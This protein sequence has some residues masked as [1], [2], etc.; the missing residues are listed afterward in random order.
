ASRIVESGIPYVAFGGGEP[1]GVPH[2]WEI[3]E[4][5]AAGGVALKLETDGT[6]ID[7]RAAERLAALGVECVQI[8]V[9]GATA[10][11]HQRVRPGGSFGPASGAIPRAVAR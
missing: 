7:E 1:L 11:P 6:R 4:R 3:F 2:C 5:L 9:D 10:A 8:A